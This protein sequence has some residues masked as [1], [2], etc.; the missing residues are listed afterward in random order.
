MSLSLRLVL[1]VSLTVL[2]VTV[3]AIPYAQIP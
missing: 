3:M 2:T 1:F